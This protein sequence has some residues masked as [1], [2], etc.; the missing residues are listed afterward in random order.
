MKSYVAVLVL[1][2]VGFY[3]LTV[4]GQ[5]VQY[6]GMP[7][8]APL[9][10]CS[11]EY[12]ENEISKTLTSEEFKKHRK[13]IFEL[14]RINKSDLTAINPHQSE[15]Y[16]RHSY[17]YINDS[18]LKEIYSAYGETKS[19]YTRMFYYKKIKSKFYNCDSLGKSPCKMVVN[20]KDSLNF[21][22]CTIFWQ[23]YFFNDTVPDNRVDVEISDSKGRIIESKTS[24]IEKGKPL[25]N[26][27][28]WWKSKCEYF[29]DTLTICQGFY[30]Q[31]KMTEYR[32][33]Y[34]SKKSKTNKL[35]SERINETYHTFDNDSTGYLSNTV[36]IKNYN[37]I[38][39]G[40]LQEILYSQNGPAYE[41][42]SAENDY[43]G[44]IKQEKRDYKLKIIY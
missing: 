19:G 20:I 7:Y 13:I 32:Y 37:Y 28:D 24:M 30:L 35:I 36:T 9:I 43:K 1:M 14:Y 3:S 12:F 33:N 26:D 34:N 25:T 4:Y 44:Q 40:L 17:Y 10:P 42:I 41:E 27:K 11:A 21:K 5:A 23:S 38:N 29:G 15:I 16:E 31:K 22:I 2:I 8:N 18:L 39:K 6:D